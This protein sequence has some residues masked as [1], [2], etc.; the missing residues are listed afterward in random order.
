[1]G[2]HIPGSPEQVTSAGVTVHADGWFGPRPLIEDNSVRSES[3]MTLNA[4]GGYT[5]KRLTFSLEVL[6]LTNSK[7]HEIDYWFT[8]QIPSDAG[9]PTNDVHYHPVEPL[10]VRG[11]VAWTF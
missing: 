11:G 6:N 8:S 9:T 1:M 3:T 4:G 5:W 7:D 10:S 2:D